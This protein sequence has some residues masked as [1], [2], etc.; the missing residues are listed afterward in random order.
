MKTKQLSIFRRMMI[1]VFI[2]ITV[3]GLLF[4]VITYL[5]STHF[6]EASTQLLNREVAGHI[7]KFASPF[8]RSGLNRQKADSVFYQAMVLSPSIEVYFLDTTG[9]V[10]Y[11]HA[12][13]SEILQWRLPL[14]NV[15]EY[16]A[17]AGKRYIKGI[18][19]K[20]PAH[21]KIFSAAAVTGGAGKL[22][23]IYVIL[24][25]KEYRAVTHLL[26]NS[27]VNNLVIKT[28]VFAI[29]ATLLISLVYVRR[30]QKNF[31]GMVKVL[32]QFEKGDFSA[33]VPV[34]E[35]DDLSPI[36][37]AFNIM[38]DQL[39]DNIEK[40]KK[41]EAD[42]KDFTTNI[43][44]DLRTPLAI[45]RGYAETM[46]LKTMETGASTAEKES[47][48]RLVIQN[49]ET[50][51]HMVQ[52]LLDLSK[53]ESGH[54]IPEKQPFVFSEIVQEFVHASSISAAARQLTIDCSRCTDV[55]WIEGDISMMERVIQNLLTNAIKYTPAGG[56]VLVSLERQQDELVFRMENMGNPLPPEIAEWINAGRRQAKA[57]RGDKGGI[58]LTIVKKILDLH[59]FTFQV[60]T[61]DSP[62]NIFIIRMPVYHAL[63]QPMKDVS[64]H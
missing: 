57:P 61:G 33:R 44:H 46:L 21:P 22:G 48:A 39:V 55:S 3:M 35:K 47:Y 37:H 7:A 18:D 4:I 32:Q 2:L 19:P 58:G 17:S 20:D 31:D 9:K 42:R 15:Q 43:S 62:V 26:Y 63:A 60:Q 8:E 13:S 24:G 54:F 1:W 41:A 40:L 56:Q 59:S 11:F 12:E 29:L 14:G 51:E 34:N 52:Q 6:Y 38:A 45:A 27:H 49:L 50:V 10:L 30:L 5:S 28:F 23:Y 25:S 64:F 53:M 36:A 16:I